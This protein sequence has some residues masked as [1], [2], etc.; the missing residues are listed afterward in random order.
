MAISGAL[1]LEGAR[2]SSR[3]RL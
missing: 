2:P 3:S 1:K